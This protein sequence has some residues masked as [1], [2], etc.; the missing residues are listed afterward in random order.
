MLKNAIPMRA[1][2]RRCWLATHR[3]P[4]DQIRAFLPPELEPVT[5]CGFA[6]LNTVVARMEAMRPQGLPAFLGMDYWH[7]G[8][9]I[10]AKAGDQEGLYFLRSDCDRRLL[11]LAGDLLTDFRFHT[12][13]IEV[14]EH[15]AATSIQVRSAGAD[16][17]LELS[18]L[19]QTA[20]R[21]GS[22][23]DSMAEAE[24]FLKY[25]PCGLAPAG[26]G[27]VNAIPIR[28]DETAWRA[29]PVEVVEQR[30]DFLNAFPGAVPE[31]VFEVAPIEYRFDRAHILDPR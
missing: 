30:W 13:H 22:V 15:G 28:R 3:V 27:R 5:H 1:F 17:R 20:L 7:V 29:R 21:P 8:Y 25:K 12:A 31:L 14:K 10:Y 24:A 19:M 2:I 23:F 26:T 6:F 16:A 18:G 11:A 9:R 4:T